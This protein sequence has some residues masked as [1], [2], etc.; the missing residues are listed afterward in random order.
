MKKVYP[1]WHVISFIES[2]KKVRYLERESK[3]KVYPAW[4]VISFKNSRKK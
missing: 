2:H 1:A 3:N 4:H